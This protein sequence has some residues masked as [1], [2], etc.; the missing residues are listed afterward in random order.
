MR[1]FNLIFLFILSTSHQGDSKKF[2][3]LSSNAIKEI[4]LEYFA[5]ISPKMNLISF[6]YKNGFSE[7]LIEEVLGNNNG[8]IAIRVLRNVQG[9]PWLQQLN[10]SSL[11]LFDSPQNFKDSIHNIT[12]LTNKR[13]RNN[14]LV[15]VHDASEK[16]IREN[17]QDGFSI[18]SVS[19]LVNESEKSMKL[20]SSF[21][22]TP[23]ACRSY[24]LLKINNFN[25][26]T[27]R[28][29]NLN[30]YPKKYSN[31]FKCGLTV[32]TPAVS[33]KQMSRDVITALADLRNFRMDFRFMNMPGDAA[34]MPEI[35]IIDDYLPYDGDQRY[36]A[37]VAYKVNRMT[38]AVPPG[39]LFT[40]LEKMFLMFDSDVWVAIG[41]TFLLALLSILVI[42]L[43]SKKI[44]NFFYGNGFASPTMNLLSIFLT[45]GQKRFPERNFARYI[46]L[47]FLIWSL[48]IRTCYQS[49]LYKH[50]QADRRK[51]GVTTFNELFD[52]GF[53][54]YRHSSSPNQST[55][56]VDGRT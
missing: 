2:H 48:I 36:V 42:N 8:S 44:Q 20:I 35:D 31:F 56:K 7:S 43:M 37:S 46:L 13:M 23:T 22:F 11:L 18:D 52:C 47:H 51:T 4:L 19:F 27:R 3:S 24:Q 6:G 54:L 40:A 41:V 50:L 39:D 55:V 28:W 12:W 9:N 21:M 17:L 14:H 10:I 45:G 5:K 38:Y 49:E 34:R 16:D 1:T 25:K 29:S 15:H 33:N 26:S 30:F 53:Y 32:A